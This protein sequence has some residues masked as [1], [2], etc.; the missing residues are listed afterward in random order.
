MPYKTLYAILHTMKTGYDKASWL[1]WSISLSALIGSFF[2]LAG[3]SAVVITLG[4]FYVVGRRYEG[5]K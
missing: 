1:F 3:A 2:G 5:I 4:F